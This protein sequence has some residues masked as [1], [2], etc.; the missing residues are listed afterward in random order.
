MAL[1][2]V[3]IDDDTFTDTLDLIERSFAVRLPRDLRHIDTAG[4][5]FDEVT[6]LR[7]PSGTGERCDSA[8]VFYLLRRIFAAV[9]P[10]ERIAPDA[11]LAE[12]SELSPKGLR[13][14]LAAQT[15]LTMPPVALG[16][17][18]LAIMLLTPIAALVMAWWVNAFAAVAMA[19]VGLCWFLAEPG[20][21][22]GPWASLR[23]LSLAIAQQ[24]VA[25][26][27]AM[28]ASDRPEDWWRS[29]ACILADAAEPVGIER[30]PLTARRIA[31][32][33]RIEVV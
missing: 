31:H 11:R 26:L 7:P 28:G 23:S 12:I 25:S 8:M 2:T 29:F 18:A 33:T 9:R 30:R 32:D 6:R 10:G 19:I 22:T 17:R 20:E 21:F 16:M 4:A 1:E 27:A 3:R 13:T 24:N 14:F 15:G 5:L